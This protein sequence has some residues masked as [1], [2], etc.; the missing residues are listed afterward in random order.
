VPHALLEG[1]RDWGPLVV[2]QIGG[3]AGGPGGLRHCVGVKD[4]Q[5]DPEPDR[6]TVLL[7]EAVDRTFALCDCD[8]VARAVPE[9]EGDENTEGHVVAA[10]VQ[11]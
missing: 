8:R 7:P 1:D 6:V 5:G 10:T 11:S 4:T 2:L 3:G 9:M